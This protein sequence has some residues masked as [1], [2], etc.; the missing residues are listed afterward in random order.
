MKS[1]KLIRLG[2]P[3]LENWEREELR[4]L[5]K[6]KR[7]WNKVDDAS[8]IFIRSKGEDLVEGKLERFHISRRFEILKEEKRLL[9]VELSY[10]ERLLFL[11]GCK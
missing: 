1:Y 7:Q 8:N 3:L 6:A 4:W 11:D 10:L 5:R 2:N 9:S